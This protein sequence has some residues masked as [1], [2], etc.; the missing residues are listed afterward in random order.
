[1]AERIDVIDMY[2]TQIFAADTIDEKESAFAAFWKIVRRRGKRLLPGLIAQLKDRSG[3][4]HHFAADALGLIGPAAQEAV[5]ALEDAIKQSDEGSAFRV[6]AA[7]ALRRIN[8][9]RRVS[10][11]EWIEECGHVPPSEVH[12]LGI[13][14]MLQETLDE[15]VADGSMEKRGEG[16]AAE[17]KVIDPANFN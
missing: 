6:L 7:N 14:M 13:W 5:G 8:P 3:F 16:S 1:M 2:V 10:V 12:Y 4:A 11:P 9:G 17:Y 15:M